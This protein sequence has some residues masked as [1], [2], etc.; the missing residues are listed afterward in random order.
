MTLSGYILETSVRGCYKAS[1][2]NLFQCCIALL[3]KMFFPILN[4]NQG[5]ESVGFNS[6]LCCWE[7][8]G[9][10]WLHH[11]C[12]CLPA[13]WMK[14]VQ[15]LWPLL[16]ELCPRSPTILQTICLNVSGFSPSLLKWD[17][18][19]W[20]SY[21]SKASPAWVEEVNKFVVFFFFFPFF[22]HWLHF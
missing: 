16:V 2:S 18:Q 19:S 21:S 9:S 8:L 4:L 5:S 22:L 10:A 7:L 3:V 6:L 15:L 14:P 17:A 11:L 20:T 1:L 13:C 12:H